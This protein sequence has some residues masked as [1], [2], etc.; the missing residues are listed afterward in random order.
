MPLFASG[1]YRLIGYALV[2]RSMTAPFAVRTTEIIR[3]SKKY[4]KDLLFEFARQ[5]AIHRLGLPKKP[6]EKNPPIHFSARMPGK[7]H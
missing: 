7:T 4:G 1:R 2:G 5:N 6:I 3:L